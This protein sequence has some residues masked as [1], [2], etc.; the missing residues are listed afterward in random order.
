VAELQQVVIAVM[1]CEAPTANT[2]QNRLLCTFL[3][4]TNGNI[5]FH[6]RPKIPYHVDSSTS[7]A[8]RLARSACVVVSSGRLV[9]GS[10]AAAMADR[11]LVVVDAVA[12]ASGVA[13]RWAV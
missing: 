1:T 12:V 13:V 4:H 9:A 7:P 10:A 8:C 5:M 3:I 6:A 11:P 2:S